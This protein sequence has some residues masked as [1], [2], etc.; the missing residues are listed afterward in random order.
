MD[1]K[2]LE[3]IE[4]IKTISTEILKKDLSKIRG[5]TERQ[6]EAI[7]KQTV[8]VQ[9]GLIKGEIDEE[10]KDYFFDGIEAMALNFVNTLK[11]LL[12]VTI[13]KLWNSI[14]DF[15]WKIVN[16]AT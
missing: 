16:S 2:V 12:S 5:F 15:L 13:E 14:V 1:N 7:A 10:L 8:L 4:G 3:I 11:G 6:V 9:E